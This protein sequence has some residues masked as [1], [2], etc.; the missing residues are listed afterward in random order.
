[1]KTPYHRQTKLTQNV[2]R[3]FRGPYGGNFNRSAYLQALTQKIDIR[4]QQNSMGTRQHST[5]A[6]R[7]SFPLPSLV[8]Q[9]SAAACRLGAHL[10]DIIGNQ[11]GG[12]EET[13]NFL[14][15]YCNSVG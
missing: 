12:V 1:M 10:F 2:I 11:H 3:Y 13:W 6:A 7:P 5:R 14:G 8:I 9:Y 15:N 4:C